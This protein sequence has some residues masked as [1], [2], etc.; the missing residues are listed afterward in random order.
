MDESWAKITSL[1]GLLVA[2]LREGKANVTLDSM[3]AGWQFPAVARGYRF[4][5][6]PETEST[7]TLKDPLLNPNV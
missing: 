5:I 6:F 1:K 7:K 2:E 4:C 3:Q